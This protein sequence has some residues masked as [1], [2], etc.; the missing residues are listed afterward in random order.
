MFVG[1]ATSNAKNAI[2]ERETSVIY[3]DLNPSW[4]DGYSMNV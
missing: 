1:S 4:G 3:N 2:T